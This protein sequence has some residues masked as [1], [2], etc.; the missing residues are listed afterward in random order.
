MSHQ[1]LAYCDQDSQQRATA[2]VPTHTSTYC[3]SAPGLAEATSSAAKAAPS[4]GTSAA[5]MLALAQ[6]RCSQTT[7][8]A[9]ATA[10]RAE[11]GLGA[12]SLTSLRA[13]CPWARVRA[14]PLA[15]A[16][17]SF[18]GW[19]AA[20]RHP[21]ASIEASAAVHP[22]SP[23]RRRYRRNSKCCSGNSDA[24]STWSGLSG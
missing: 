23:S 2:S 17:A 12:A 4:A 6:R 14:R 16:R 19:S 20:A 24:S 13:S 3:G 10:A 21:R 22:Q 7:C 15:Q 8:S 18:P 11:K 5:R 1:S 9:A